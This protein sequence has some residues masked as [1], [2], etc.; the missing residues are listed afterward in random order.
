VN[1]V[2]NHLLNRLLTN[3]A[4]WAAD[5]VEQDRNPGPLEPLYFTD[6]ADVPTDLP[7]MWLLPTLR[8]G[9]AA[10]DLAADAPLSWINPLT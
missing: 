7:A 4:A 6:P 1:Q 8:P 9:Q 5:R 10:A 2:N 3:E